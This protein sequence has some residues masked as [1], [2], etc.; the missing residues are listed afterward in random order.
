MEGHGNEGFLKEE[1]SFTEALNESL[2][3]SPISPN[4]LD[5]R[6]EIELKALVAR[7]SNGITFQ[8]GAVK[9]GI[10]GNDVKFLVRTE[11][12]DNRRS[13]YH[14]PDHIAEEQVFKLSCA[15]EDVKGLLVHLYMIFKKNSVSF[16][17]HAVH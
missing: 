12:I 6:P 10:F 11:P 9:S 15:S 8:L 2:A 3:I 17:C 13:P 5:W 4:P 14:P 1:I 16:T 7:G